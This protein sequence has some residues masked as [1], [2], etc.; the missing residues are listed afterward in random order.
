MSS[1]TFASSF[2]NNNT[3]S[4]DETPL[5]CY[6]MKRKSEHKISS[7]LSPWNKRY[8]RLEKIKG[9]ERSSLTVCY[10]KKKGEIQPCG[11]VLCMMYC[12]Q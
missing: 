5:E 7:W 4:S 11:Y 2:S 10:Y 12:I 9:T 8:F 1:T 3:L 6:M